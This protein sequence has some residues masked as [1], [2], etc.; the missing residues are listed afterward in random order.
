V[1]CQPGRVRMMGGGGGGGEGN[2]KGLLQGAGGGRQGV[3]PNAQ[4]PTPNAPNAPKQQGKYLVNNYHTPLRCQCPEEGLKHRGRLAALGRPGTK[5]AST[6]DN[7]GRWVGGT[8]LVHQ[9]VHHGAVDTV[10][11]ATCL[12]PPHGAVVL[13]HSGLHL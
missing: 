6:H 3:T 1:L 7:D 5:V 11:P 2:N 13:V 9:L 8:Q 12:R 10:G 4:R